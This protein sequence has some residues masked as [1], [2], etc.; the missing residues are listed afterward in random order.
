MKNRTT[1]Y[2]TWALLAILATATA[3]VC[4]TGGGI[5]SACGIENFAGFGNRMVTFLEFFSY[6]GSEIVDG[7]ANMILNV[8]DAI[9]NILYIDFCESLLG[10]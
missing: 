2:D 1:G 3:V 9:Y 8:P 7:L 6:K 4:C 10:L 5:H